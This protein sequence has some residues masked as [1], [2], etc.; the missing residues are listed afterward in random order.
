MS[1]FD[2]LLMSG[3]QQQESASDRMT[4]R[5]LRII[6]EAMDHCICKTQHRSQ[7][8]VGCNDCSGITTITNV[9]KKNHTA[10]FCRACVTRQLSQP[11]ALICVWN[12]SLY[13]G[14]LSAQRSWDSAA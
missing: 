14:R 7:T 6:E 1:S 3:G 4:I 13:P 5:P 11:S 2:D 12:C 8:A 10:C 9:K